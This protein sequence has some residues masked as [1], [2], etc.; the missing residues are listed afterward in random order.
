[1]EPCAYTLPLAG[2][3]VYNDWISSWRRT[4]SHPFRGVKYMNFQFAYSLSRFVNS[5]SNTCSP[6]CAAGG[7]QDFVNNALDN[8]NPNRSRLSTTTLHNT[9]RPPSSDAENVA[10]L[11]R[12]VQA[13]QDTAD[14]H[15]GTGADAARRLADGL[16]KLAQAD[17]AQ[18][19]RATDA[20]IHPL[21][22]DL[23]DVG[24]SLMAERVTRASLPPDTRA[25]LDCPGWPG[26]DRN[27]AQGR[28]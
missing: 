19:A 13:V 18:R 16:N 26:T 2:R 28:R 6:T 24:Q 20:F 27:L 4:S 9:P 15:S 25:R 21:Q 10:A 17:A 1:M 3:S 5:G 23:D 14:Q 8:R 12:A 7:D 11:N 22:L